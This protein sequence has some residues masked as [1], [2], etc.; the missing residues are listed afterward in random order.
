VKMQAFKCP[1]S[2][3][4]YYVGLWHRHSIMVVGHKFSVCAH[5][6]SVLVGVAIVGRPVSRNL[7]NGNTLE[8]RRVATDGTRNACSF[9]YAEC[10]RRAIAQGCN[11]LVTYT[12]EGESGSSLRALG[13]GEPVSL[14]HGTENWHTRTGRS[15][16]SRANFRWELI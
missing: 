15:N 1:L 3:A 14:S 7:D 10:K 4:N 6:N 8:V 12:Q 11:R 2:T 5:K 9:L 13:L 16:T